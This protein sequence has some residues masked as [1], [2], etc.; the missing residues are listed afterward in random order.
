LLPKTIREIFLRCPGYGFNLPLRIYL[1][2]LGRLLV[3]SQMSSRVSLLVI[4]YGLLV[5]RFHYCQQNHRISLSL[6]WSRPRQRRLKFKRFLVLYRGTILISRWPIGLHLLFGDL[7]ILRLASFFYVNVKCHH[8][9]LGQ[10]PKIK[11]KE[12]KEK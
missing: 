10:S 9:T 12:K 7:M 2:V 11:K 8:V 6:F 4:L 3:V 5:Q 1:R